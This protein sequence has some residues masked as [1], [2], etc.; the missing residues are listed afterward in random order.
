M[1]VRLFLVRHGSTA[2]NA[3]GRFLGW[4]DEALNE[5]GLS[6]AMKIRE[7]IGK[8]SFQSQWTSDLR[9]AVETADVIGD[10]FRQDSRLREIDMGILE[11]KSWDECEPEVQQSLID[12]D[13]FCAPGGESVAQ[14]R[15]RVNKFLEALT[16]GDHLIVTHGGVI[17]M[18]L[19]EIEGD[20][21]VPTG[22]IIGI[23]WT[24]RSLVDN[25]E[26]EPQTNRNPERNELSGPAES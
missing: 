14:L 23:D 5:V 26:P 18:V 6:Q 22:S 9:R 4:G 7:A 2:S 24:N 16:E 25:A 15:V 11:S 10:D 1:T 21:T 12:F 13:D 3:A 20:R 17:R 19:R 8:M